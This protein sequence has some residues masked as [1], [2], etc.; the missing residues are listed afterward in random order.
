[1]SGRLFYFRQVI[2]IADS[3]S[4]KTDWVVVDHSGKEI[5]RTRTEGYNPMIVSSDFIYESIGSSALSSIG[6]QLKQVHFYGAGCSSADRNKVVEDALTRLFMNAEITV[7]H[8][9]LAAARATCGDG[10]GIVS[11]LGTGSNSCLYQNG[12]I[13]AQ[14]PNL[15]YLLGD[16]GGGYGLGRHLMKAYMYSEISSDLCNKL[17]QE[18]SVD[19]TSFISELYSDILKNRY[20]ASFAPFCYKYKHEDE[21]RQLVIKNFDEFIEHHLLKYE[22]TGDL[23]F[24]FIGSIASFFSEEL[25]ESL[26]KKGLEIGVVVKEP[27]HALMNYHLVQH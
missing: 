21:I 10:D 22:V 5:L 3:G 23:K 12:E 14:V 2:V 11:I 19:R 27:I 17:E 15:G 7:H 13:V 26:T 20:V 4:T 25:V 8:D 9:I 16:E 18:Y 1:M 24:H 6:T